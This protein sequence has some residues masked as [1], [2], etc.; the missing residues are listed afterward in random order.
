MTEL[1]AIG[2]R[3]G[4]ANRPAP[5]ADDAPLRRAAEAF[6]AAFL[7]EMLKHSGL[8]RMPE[9]FNGGAGEQGF[10]D[11]LVREYATRIAETKSLGLAERIFQAMAARAAR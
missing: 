9:A 2:A 7:T 3:A 6:E 5:A 4:P 8:G 11:F 10:A 1:Q